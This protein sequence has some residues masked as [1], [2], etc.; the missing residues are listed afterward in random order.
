MLKNDI[1]LSGYTDKD[2][3]LGLGVAAYIE[4]YYD[5]ATIELSADSG[6]T[7]ET[8]F[9]YTGYARYWHFPY[10]FK[11]PDKFKTANF[12]LRFHLTSDGSVTHDGWLI[13]SVGIGTSLTSN[14]EY[15]NG[16]SMATPHVS[17]AIAVLG[18]VFTNDTIAERKE[19][20]MSSVDRIADL[21]GKM[22]TGGRLNL[23]SALQ[24]GIPEDEN[25]TAGEHF[26][27]GTGICVPGTAVADKGFFLHN[28]PEG[29]RMVQGIDDTNT[30]TSTTQ[31]R[32]EDAYLPSP[33]CE[34]DQRPVQGT[35][36]CE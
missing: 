18:S 2:L 8:L 23:L 33:S 4:D 16:T 9:D 19:R 29:E 10:S 12:R 36:R 26:L 21:D 1:D 32:L 24:T 31:K 34:S 5:H 17:G 25:C 6:S 22:V 15:K 30:C 27:Q 28:C 11:I 20:I 3:Y 7:W 13:D 14:Y 35:E